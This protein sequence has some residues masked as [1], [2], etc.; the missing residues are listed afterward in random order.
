LLAVK[1]TGVFKQVVYVAE[2]K[3]TVGVAVTVIVV[4]L[5]AA[6]QPVTVLVPTTV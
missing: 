4:V 3:F 6:W 5:A 2:V 1:V